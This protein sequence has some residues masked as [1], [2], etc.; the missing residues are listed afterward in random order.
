MRDVVPVQ[1]RIA[2]ISASFHFATQF[3]TIIVC[4]FH[5]DSEAAPLG[6]TLSISTAIQMVALAW[7]QTKYPLIAIHHGEGKRERAGTLWRHTALVSTVLLS[8]GFGT[9]I[10]LI[11][12]LPLLGETLP[13]RFLNPGASRTAGHRRTSQSHSRNPRFL[14]TCNE[15]Q[16]PTCGIVVWIDPHRCIGLDRRILLQYKRGARRI[17]SRYGTLPRSSSHL[18]LYPISEKPRANLRINRFERVHSLT[19]Q[20]NPRFTWS[21]SGLTTLPAIKPPLKCPYVEQIRFSH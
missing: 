19:R 14:C 3:F 5:S 9:L 7:V 12:C 11:S 16:T 15:S 1:W 20:S 2:L 21:T 4:K 10:L 8:L 6:M 18:G 17:R 13:D